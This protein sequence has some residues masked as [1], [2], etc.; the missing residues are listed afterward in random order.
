MPPYAQIAAWLR[1]LIASGELGP[2]DRLPSALD[3]SQ[4]FGVAIMTA[5]KALALLVDENLA[6]R[7]QG[8]GTFVR[9]R[10]AP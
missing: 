6:Y 10:Q 2:G 3:L 5:R 8:L 1:G 9:E 4:S 7:S